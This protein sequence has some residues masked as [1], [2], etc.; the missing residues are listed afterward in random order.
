M[1]IYA[2]PLSLS[3]K[4][5]VVVRWDFSHFFFSQN[6]QIQCFDISKLLKRGCPAK[7]EG[8]SKEFSNPWVDYAPSAP[9]VF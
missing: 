9:T 3:E 2:I 1:D 4:V 6:D 7:T 8:G 5:I